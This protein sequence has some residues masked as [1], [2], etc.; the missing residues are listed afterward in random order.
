M[1]NVFIPVEAGSG[2]WV[3][4]ENI[5]SWGH[6]EIQV[7]AAE[8]ERDRERERERERKCLESGHRKG[9]C[10]MLLNISSRRKIHFICKC[11]GYENTR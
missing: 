10:C 9:P 5:H 4:K 2:C 3:R 7:A 11:I 6:C 8:R 1:S